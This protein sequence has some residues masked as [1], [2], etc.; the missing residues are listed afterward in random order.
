MIYKGGAELLDLSAGSRIVSI[1]I[2]PVVGMFVRQNN[3][4]VAI[5]YLIMPFY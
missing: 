2:I 4:G 3:T 5:A 1:M